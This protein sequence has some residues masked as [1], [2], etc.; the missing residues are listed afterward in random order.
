METEKARKEIIYQNGAKYEEDVGVNGQQTGTGKLYDNSGTLLYVGDWKDD[1]CNG[2]GTYHYANGAKYEGDWFNDKKHGHGT[3]HYANGA[4]YEGDW[5]N[6]KKHGHGTYYWPNGSRYEGEWKDN[7]PNKDENG[8]Y[9]FPNGLP[10][11]GKIV[12]GRPVVGDVDNML[13]PNGYKRKVK[14]GP[15]GDLVLEKEICDENGLKVAD[16]VYYLS[17]N[18]VYIGQKDEKNQPNGD[19]TMLFNNG[20]V[21]KGSWKDDSLKSNTEVTIYVP[22]YNE[23]INVSIGN[24]GAFTSLKEKMGD[25]VEIKNGHV[26]INKENN[27]AHL[28]ASGKS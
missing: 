23:A 14:I 17:D 20:T 2:H 22:E 4:K 9:F 21:F 6:D 1:K 5:L 15:K 19:C 18:R 24:N 7:A 13:F 25:K 3:Y 28:T 8:E 11:Q 26:Y 16:N 12:N 27:K 10:Y